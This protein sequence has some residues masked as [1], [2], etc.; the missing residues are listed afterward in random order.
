ML[1]GI[2]T[3]ILLLTSLVLV[4]RH[5]HAISLPYVP[6]PPDVLAGEGVT[7]QPVFLLAAA[8]SGNIIDRTAWTV[9]CDSAQPEYPCQNAIDGDP[10]TF[11]HTQ[12]DPVQAPLPHTI[13]IDMKTIYYV[14]GLT[15]LP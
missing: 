1:R 14:N 2:T 13:T 5:A 12:Y 9:V 7:D 3:G 8:P 11:W 10:N 15:Y 4:D 6:P